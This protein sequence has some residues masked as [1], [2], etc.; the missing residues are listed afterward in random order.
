MQVS[1]GFAQLHAAATRYPFPL[2]GSIRDEVFTRRGGLYFG[3]AHLLERHV[4]ES[5]IFNPSGI[6]EEFSRTVRRE[7]DFVTEKNR[8]VM[9]QLKEML[10]GQKE[11]SS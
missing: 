6:V 10:N 7:M 3:I 5:R 2:Q 9:Q 4:P 11:S 1:I 8:R